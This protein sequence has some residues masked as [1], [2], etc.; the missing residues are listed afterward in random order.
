MLKR[1]IFFLSYILFF[2]GI[3]V[4]VYFFWPVDVDSHSLGN[5]DIQ[6][7]PGVGLDFDM[8][9]Y[10]IKYN[11]LVASLYRSGYASLAALICFLVSLICTFF[12]ALRKYT[13]PEK[14]IGGIAIG[15]CIFNLLYIPVLYFSLYINPLIMGY[16]IY[17]IALI[18]IAFWIFL[19]I[20]LAFF[21]PTVFLIIF[22]MIRGRR[23]VNK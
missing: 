12:I 22:G 7:A 13:R 19:V 15:A 9:T 11:S 16:Y 4:C 3:P 21:I 17:A 20:V 6:E 1:Y 5:L 10:N 18:Y 8:T 23:I 2:A 14:K